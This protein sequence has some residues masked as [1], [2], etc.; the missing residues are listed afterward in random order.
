MSRILIV[1]ENV[2]YQEVV[3]QALLKIDKTV[4]K[5]LLQDK[6]LDPRDKLTL[7]RELNN[8]LE[9]YTNILKEQE[10]SVLDILNAQEKLFKKSKLVL[11]T[12]PGRKSE[13]IKVFLDK[14]SIFLKYP[15]DYEKTYKSI[16]SI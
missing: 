4:L 8:E 5:R 13:E 12:H 3:K 10:K 7:N 2:K 15:L 14:A 11:L 9:Q 16:L 1:N 6:D